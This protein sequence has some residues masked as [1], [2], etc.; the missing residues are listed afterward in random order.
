LVVEFSQSA[1]KFACVAPR[2]IVGD[3]VQDAA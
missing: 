1:A 3:D 2:Q